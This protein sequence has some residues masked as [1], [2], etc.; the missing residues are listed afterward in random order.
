MVMRF[1]WGLAVGHT[2]THGDTHNDTASVRGSGE[3][4]GQAEEC[5]SELESNENR[6]GEEGILPDEARVYSLEDPDHLDWD[7]ESGD[8]DDYWEEDLRASIVES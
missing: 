3:A 5:T 2:Y 6:Q 4:D 7:D 1:H 8:E